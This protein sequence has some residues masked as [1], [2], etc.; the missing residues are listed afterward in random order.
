[1]NGETVWPPQNIRRMTP[2]QRADLNRV[3]V[4]S[5]RLWRRAQ[6]RVRLALT[7][8]GPNDRPACRYHNRWG[9]VVAITALLTE[10]REAP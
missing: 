5:A 2:E 8:Y 10:R 3:F 6:P 4:H 1:M 9:T 7:V